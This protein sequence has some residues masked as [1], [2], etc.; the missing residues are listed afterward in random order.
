MLSRKKDKVSLLSA[1]QEKFVQEFTNG[2]FAG[3]GTRSAIA[4]GYSAKTA[5]TIAWTVLH[6]PHVAQAI[7]AA[8]REAIS[9]PMAARAVN[10]L[11][12]VV[13]DEEAPLKLRADVACRIVEFSGVVQRAQL[14]KA[15]STGLDGAASS[16]GKRLGELTRQ[17]LE[18]LVRNG[19]AL[20][21]AAASLPPAKETL[22]GSKLETFEQTPGT[23]Q[24][25]HSSFK[26]LVAPET[27]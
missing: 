27:I 10:F 9:G 3:N 21:A 16:D 11:R 26:A 4:A 15:R 22:E 14:E 25:K 1:Q 2:K 7:D 13:D 24:V 17:E 23:K 18:G 6:V 19:A 20:L 5:P 8:L 12:R